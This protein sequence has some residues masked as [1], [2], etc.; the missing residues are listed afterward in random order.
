MGSSLIVRLLNCVLIIGLILIF[1][2]ATASAEVII[3]EV[4]W[5]GSD[6]EAVGGYRD[7]WF[8]LHATK[9]TDLTDWKIIGERY[10]GKADEE[11]GLGGSIEANGYI[12]FGNVTEG[13]DL[14]NTGLILK[15][16]DGSGNLINT[17]VGGEDWENIGGDNKKPKK[18]AQYINGD[19]YTAL[20][21]RGAVNVK[22]P[23]EPDPPEDPDPDPEPSNTKSSQSS[24]QSSSKTKAKADKEETTH[25]KPVSYTHLTLPTILLV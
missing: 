18:T 15:L 8:E 23:S 25:S 13:L 21:T 9:A 16:Y 24:N 7:E 1:Y 6:D 22:P 11:Y 12:V 4:A 5:M 10:D 19:W 3:S 20:P 14:I 17:V 2:P